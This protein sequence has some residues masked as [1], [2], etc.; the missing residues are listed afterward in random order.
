MKKQKLKVLPIQNFLLAKHRTTQ[1]IAFYFLP[2]FCV[3]F[4]HIYVI[5]FYF[6]PD[7][8]RD[9]VAELPLIKANSVYISILCSATHFTQIH[10]I[11]HDINLIQVS[12]NIKKNQRNLDFFFWGLAF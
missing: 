2:C 11:T 6:S 7:G 4:N 9:S 1:H 8:Y 10:I 3:S 12:V 5:C